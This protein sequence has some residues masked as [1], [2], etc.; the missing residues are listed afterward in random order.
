MSVQLH[1]PLGTWWLTGLFLDPYVT[2]LIS[3]TYIDFIFHLL[4]S[5]PLDISSLYFFNPKSQHSATLYFQH[6]GITWIR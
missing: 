6:Y 3:Q 5:N 2:N 1:T 4:L